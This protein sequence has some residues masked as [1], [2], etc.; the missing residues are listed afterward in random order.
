MSTW[1]KDNIINLSTLNLIKE[2]EENIL[3]CTGKRD[4]FL[5]GTTRMN[6]KWTIN[7]RYFMKPKSFCNVRDTIKT[8]K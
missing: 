8:T 6:T 3:E 2:K 5:N 7:K 4:N 1:I